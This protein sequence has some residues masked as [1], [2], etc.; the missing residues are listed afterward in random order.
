MTVTAA[1][2]EL[3]EKQACPYASKK[4]IA[5]LAG[6]L[7]RDLGCTR[8]Y[9]CDGLTGRGMYWLDSDGSRLSPKAGGE[10]YDAFVRLYG[11]R[12]R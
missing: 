7:L 12:T 2:K 1:Y 6:R 9:Q 10:A 3:Q 8:E 11:R 5:R 4:A